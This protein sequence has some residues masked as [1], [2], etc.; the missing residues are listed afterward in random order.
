MTVYDFQAATIAGAD[1]SLR[2]Y[3]G[4]VLLIVNT[5]SK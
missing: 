1:V 2:Q 5:A 4:Q 3:E